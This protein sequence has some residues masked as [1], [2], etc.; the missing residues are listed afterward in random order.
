MA[1][2]RN[3]DSNQEQSV[4]HHGRRSFFERFFKAVLGLWGAAFAGVVLYY[5]KAPSGLQAFEEKSKRVGPLSELNVG[6]AKF[7]AHEREP[8]WVVRTESNQVTAL[9][10]T[11]T[12][13]HCVLQWEKQSGRLVCPCHAGAFDLNGNVVSGPPPRPLRPLRVDV[14]GGVVYVSVS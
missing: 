2:D 6:E 7:V 1:Q 10:A 11:C 8:F 9:P 12:H 13:L 4:E 14:K 3:G 5:V